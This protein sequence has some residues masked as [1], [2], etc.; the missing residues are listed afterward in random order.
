[1]IKLPMTN[2][3]LENNFFAIK[4]TKSLKITQQVCKESISKFKIKLILTLY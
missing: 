3:K 1:M 4:A 2:E